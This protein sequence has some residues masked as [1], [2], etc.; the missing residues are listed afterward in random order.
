M[1]TSPGLARLADAAETSRTGD[2]HMALSNDSNHQPSFDADSV[3]ASGRLRPRRAAAASTSHATATPVSQKRPRPANRPA[4][5]HIPLAAKAKLPVKKKTKA[6]AQQKH[7]KSDEHKT[8]VPPGSSSRY[9]SEGAIGPHQGSCGVG[10]GKVHKV[11][12]AAGCGAM[13]ALV[14]HG[15]GWH[16]AEDASVIFHLPTPGA[17]GDA[18]AAAWQPTKCRWAAMASATVD[19]RICMR[20]LLSL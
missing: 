15:T 16:A 1:R 14:A 17:P 20:F 9:S 5:K 19:R 6:T 12:G 8:T 7:R 3:T 18:A 13:P 11:A 10:G 2:S 4:L